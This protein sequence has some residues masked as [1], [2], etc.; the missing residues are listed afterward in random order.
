MD[1]KLTGEE[2]NIISGLHQYL[3]LKQDFKEAVRKYIFKTVAAQKQTHLH[4]EQYY[5]RECKRM[6]DRLLKLQDLRAQAES[7]LKTNMAI[8]SEMDILLRSK[9]HDLK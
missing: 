8:V 6:K 9:D 2:D 7:E 4:K 5:L 1:F 3:D